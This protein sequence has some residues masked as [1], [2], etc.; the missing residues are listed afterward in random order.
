[1]YCVWEVVKT[2]TIILNNPVY[3]SCLVNGVEILFVDEDTGK[4]EGFGYVVL[5]L[6]Q[7]GH[8]TCNSKNSVK[9][10]S[11]TMALFFCCGAATQRGSWPPRS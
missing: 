6:T 9:L 11:T 1:M 10:I 2:E 4:C 8:H 7:Y 3:W 5:L